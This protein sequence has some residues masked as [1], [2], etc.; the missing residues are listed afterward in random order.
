MYIFPRAKR[1]RKKLAKMNCERYEKMHLTA[2]LTSKNQPFAIFTPTNHHL[3]KF[4]NIFENIGRLAEHLGRLAPPS[5]PL[6][7]FMSTNNRRIQRE[8]QAFL[9]GKLDLPPQEILKPIEFLKNIQ[10]IMKID[11]NGHVRYLFFPLLNAKIISS[12]RYRPKLP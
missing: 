10:N 7:P 5:P 6:S 2:F 12:A 9:Y 4:P 8:G 3:L 11:E 1:G